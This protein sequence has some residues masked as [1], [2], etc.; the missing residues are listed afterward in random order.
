MFRPNVLAALFVAGMIAAATPALADRGGN[1]NGPGARDV[2][3]SIQVATVN[4]RAASAVNGSL[5][6]SY[7]DSLT[8]ATTVEKLAGWEWPMVS[9]TCY[10]SGQLV[11]GLLDHPDATFTLAGSSPWANVG[12]D[13]VCHAD[14]D[15][16][17]FKGSGESIRV[18]DSSDEW[19]ATWPTG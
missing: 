3:S 12:G 17:G 13:A 14:L 19:A 16:Y 15:A 1:G 2:Q 18:L 4:G 8:F 10:Q 6:V 5:T 7:G 9:L 11:F